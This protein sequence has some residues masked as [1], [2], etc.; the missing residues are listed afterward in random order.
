MLY[1]FH[2]VFLNYRCIF[3]LKQYQTIYSD[4]ER[5]HYGL[6]FMDRRDEIMHIDCIE[7]AFV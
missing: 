7:M 5:V 6:R 4:W 3:F 1:L 2:F